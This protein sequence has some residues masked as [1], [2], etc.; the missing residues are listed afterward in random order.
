MGAQVDDMI[1]GYRPGAEPDLSRGRQWTFWPYT[2]TGLGSIGLIV[3][4][5]IWSSLRR[6]TGMVVGGLALLARWE[7]VR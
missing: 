3:L 4:A 2:H 1:R 6:K 7:V 5:L